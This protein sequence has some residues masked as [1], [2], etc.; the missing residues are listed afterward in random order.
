M[1]ND[2]FLSPMSDF[3]PL[4]PTSQFEPKEHLQ[5]SVL[6]AAVTQHPNPL[7]LQEAINAKL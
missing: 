4:H 5:D 7:S 3:A 6:E 2:A 1:I